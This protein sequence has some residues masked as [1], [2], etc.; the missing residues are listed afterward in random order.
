MNITI[1]FMIMITAL[2]LTGI[3]AAI[4][5]KIDRVKHQRLE[6]KRKFIREHKGYGLDTKGNIVKL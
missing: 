4:F 5:D 2:M 1:I 3:P 6:K